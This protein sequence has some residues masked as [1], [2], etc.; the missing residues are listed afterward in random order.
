MNY[1]LRIRRYEIRNGSGGKGL[2]NGGSGIIRE[3][4]F[5]QAARVTILSERRTH[6]PYGLNGGGLGKAGQNFLNN[7]LINGKVSLSVEPGDYVRIETPG[8]GAFGLT[9]MATQS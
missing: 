4:E 5:L 2:Q 3:F 1:P 6:A 7:Q 8:G 9:E